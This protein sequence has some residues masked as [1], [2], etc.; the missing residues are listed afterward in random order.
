MDDY[1][2]LQEVDR[3]LAAS[4]IESALV[5]GK[6]EQQKQLERLMAVRRLHPERVA[7]IGCGHGGV[8]RHLSVLYPATGYTLVDR[9]ETALSFA[10][11][12]VHGL[13]ATCVRA[14]LYDLPLQPGSHDVVICWQTLSWINR[15]AD[16][17]REMIRICAPG[18]RVFISSLFNATADVDVYSRV[19]D[20]TR[21]SAQLGLGMFYNTYSLRTI[22]EWVAGSV[23][24]VT[25]HELEMPLDLA[26]QGRG[27]GTFTIQLADGKRL[28]V[29]GGMLM[30]WG[31]LELTK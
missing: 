21:P 20:H 30:N 11:R 17:L 26:R 14:D 19:V 9:F 13:R 22:T 27:L 29:S 24:D 25:L 15:P 7:D 10:A 5:E 3:H 31:I 4:Y 12:T 28:Q 8:V 1:R 6:Q 16:A 18:G 2:E 23:A